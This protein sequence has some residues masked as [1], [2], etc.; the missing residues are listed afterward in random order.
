MEAGRLADLLVVDGDP[1]ADLR[2]LRAVRHVL[3]DGR[4]V[5]GRHR[6]EPDWPAD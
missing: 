4:F 1:V 3:R 6:V 5:G 2:A